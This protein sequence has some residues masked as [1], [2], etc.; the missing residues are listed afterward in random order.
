MNITILASFNLG[1][2]RDMKCSDTVPL[3]LWISG[4]YLYEYEEAIWQ[5]ISAGG[6]VDTLAAMV[7][8]IVALSSGDSTIPEEWRAYREELPDWSL[9]AE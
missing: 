7:G 6:D 1:N 8:G 3:A 5:T 9:G 2:G 4:S